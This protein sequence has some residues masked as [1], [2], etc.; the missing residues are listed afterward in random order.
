MTGSCCKLYSV[1]TALFL[2]PRKAHDLM[3]MTLMHG[4]IFSQCTVD[5]PNFE[6]CCICV[7]RCLGNC[8]FNPSVTLLRANFYFANWCI[9]DSRLIEGGALTSLTTLSLVW[10][11]IIFVG[12]GV[13]RVLNHMHVQRNEGQ[14]LQWLI[15]G[16][17][18]ANCWIVVDSCLIMAVPSS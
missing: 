11:P 7:M 15:S 5:Y 4:C 18:I 17:M 10:V 3:I 12:R 1:Y 9:P 2:S 13:C 8:L 16:L 14:I 6:P